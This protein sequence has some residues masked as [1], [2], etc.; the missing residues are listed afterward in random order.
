MK[1]YKLARSI[2]VMMW[3]FLTV[4]AAVG[5]FLVVRVLGWTASP[6]LPQGVVF[7]W[8]GLLAW[9]WY[10]YLR[11]P[12]AITLRDDQV[13]EFRSFLKRTLVAPGDLLSIKAVPL[14]L[15]FINIRHKGGKIRLINQ[16]TGLYELICTVKSLNPNI[17]IQGC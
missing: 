6:A 2:V 10:S 16:I 17:E 4:L 3:V 7:I 15:G 9:I 14:S 13:L 11:I 12:Y 5:A 1:V 8:L